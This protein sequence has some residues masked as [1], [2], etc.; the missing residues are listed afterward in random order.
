MKRYYDCSINDYSNS[1][2]NIISNGPIENDIMMDLKKYAH[3]YDFE[4]IYD[5]KQA[6]I[7][8]TNTIYPDNIYEW[9]QKYKIPLV[10]RMDGIYW[11]NDLKYKNIHLNNSALKS[12]MVI[13][14]SEYSKNALY[15]LYNINLK[16]SVVILNNSDDTIFHKNYNK[17]K[18]K[19]FTFVSSCTNWSRYGKRLENLIDFSKIITYELKDETEVKRELACVSGVCDIV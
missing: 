8:I 1:N 6:D 18:N 17:N 10:K 2:H 5:Y 16:N 13:F 14:I 11:Q 3:L 12:N 7:I 15:E 4:R 9:S 19:N